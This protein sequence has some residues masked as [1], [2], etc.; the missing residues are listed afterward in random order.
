[1]DFT[2]MLIIP[3]IIIIALIACAAKAM[4]VDG[5]GFSLSLIITIVLSIILIGSL[6]APVINDLNEVREVYYDDYFETNATSASGSIELVDIDG[7]TYAHAKSIG[8]GTLTTPNSVKT[9][10]VVKADLDVWMLSGQSNAAY[11]GSGRYDPSTATP[12]PKLGTSYYYGTESAPVVYDASFTPD[13]TYGIFDMMNTTT[14]AAKIGNIELPFA[15][16]YGTKTDHKVLVVNGARSGAHIEQFVPNFDVCA[17]MKTVFN[18]AMS[19]IDQDCYNVSVKGLIWAQGESNDD[20]IIETYEMYFKQMWYSVSGQDKAHIFSE[21]DLPTCMIIQTREV[22]SANAAEAQENLAAE[23]DN[24]YLATEVTQTFTIENGMMNSDNLHYSQLGDNAIG[25][26]IADYYFTNIATTT[27]TLIKNMFYNQNR[28]LWLMNYEETAGDHTITFGNNKITVDDV[29]WDLSDC[30]QNFRDIALQTQ[31]FSV[32]VGNS[33]HDCYIYL[34][35]DSS[36]ILTPSTETATITIEDGTATIIAN[37]GTPKTYAVTWCYIAD[38]EGDYCMKWAGWPQY[39]ENETTLDIT[40]NMYKSGSTAIYHDGVCH[41]GNLTT[42]RSYSINSEVVDDTNNQIVKI[43]GVTLNGN[44][45]GTNTTY[46]IVPLFV[47][48][49]TT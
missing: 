17:F 25:A 7:Q 4:V 24:V 5:E 14:G 12:V 36:I 8:K 38:L 13:D 22:N 45:S 32:N 48:Y 49:T 6:M 20:T 16:E 18:D 19:K 21:Y 27:P 9:Y 10:N 33:E 40:S 35:N 41:H 43:N 23:L 44:S 29:T 26:D 34:A 37:N 42:N 3:A 1:M 47:T 28:G 39:V 30:T 15:G 31:F 11:Y 2:L 46:S